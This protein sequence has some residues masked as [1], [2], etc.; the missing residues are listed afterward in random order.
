MNLS[1]SK[2]IAAL[3]LCSAII[4]LLLVSLVLKALTYKGK[5]DGDTSEPKQKLKII[6][7][8]CCYTQVVNVDDADETGIPGPA[9]H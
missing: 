8:S 2:G 7:R 3:V 4:L 9:R 5:N 1:Y 6:C